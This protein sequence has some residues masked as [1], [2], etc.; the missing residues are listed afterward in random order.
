[1]EQ[2]R[3]EVAKLMKEVQEL[4]QK[5]TQTEGTCGLWALTTH[6]L[7]HSPP[8]RINESPRISGLI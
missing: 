6:R 5:V 8:C 7:T 4:R 2:Q 1:M 3:L